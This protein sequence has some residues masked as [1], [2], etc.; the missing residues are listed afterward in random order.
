M[1]KFNFKGLGL[2]FVKM[3]EEQ[4]E[5]QEEFY[6]ETI[7]YLALNPEKVKSFSEEQLK[8]LLNP[9]RIKSNVGRIRT[10]FLGLCV[11]ETINKVVEFINAISAYLD[12]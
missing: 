2:F 12:R 7:R 11:P 9:K 3:F 5:V 1:K 4:L 6:P 10:I 8:A